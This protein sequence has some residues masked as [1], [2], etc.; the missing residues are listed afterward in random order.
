MIYLGTEHYEQYVTQEDLIDTIMKLPDIYTEP[1]ADSSQIPTVM[2]SELTKSHVT[3]SLS[4]DGGDELFGG[5]G[6]YFLGE[7]LKK[8]I[9][10]APHSLR[11]F[12]KNNNLLSLS[13]PIVSGLFKNTVSGFNQKFNKLENII[14]YS[15]DTDLYSRLAEF[16]DSPINTNSQIQLSER[17]WSSDISFFEKAMLQDSVDYLPGD[18]L[19]KVDMAGMSVS[20]ETR[21]PLL[22]HKIAELA[23]TLPFHFLHSKGQGKYIFKDIVHDFIPQSIMDRPKKG[24]DIP[25]SDYLRGELRDYSESKIKYG[26]N[27]FS[28]NL[29]FI[30]IYK[31]WDDH[32]NYI[33]DSPNLLWNIISFF[34]WHEAN[35][36]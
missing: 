20:L 23:S 34:A 19:T 6:R 35:M 7:K 32:Q 14:D 21:I 10:M 28:E 5:Y 30:K 27:I 18:I 4:G 12:I 1:F 17:I 8:T 13:R 3:V 15:N 24:F 36:H 33:L 22:N 29:D 26:E 31:L 2:L 16:P 9:G 11:K 25:L